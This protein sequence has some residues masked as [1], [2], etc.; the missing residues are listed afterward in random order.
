MDNE[1]GLKI[2]QVEPSK[3]W[4]VGTLTR[5][6]ILR[7]QPATQKKDRNHFKYALPFGILTFCTVLVVTIL[8]N[9]H[10]VKQGNVGPE[11]NVEEIISNTKYPFEIADTT[12]MLGGSMVSF[13]DSGLMDTTSN[14]TIPEATEA[15]EFTKFDDSPTKLSQP[16]LETSNLIENQA[17]TTVNLERRLPVVEINNIRISSISYSYGP[18]KCYGIDQG[19]SNDRSIT[20][21]RITGEKNLFAE[22]EEMAISKDTKKQVVLNDN[23]ES[24][25]NLQVINNLGSKFYSKTFDGIVDSYELENIFEVWNQAFLVNFSS[26]SKNIKFIGYDEKFDQYKFTDVVQVECAMPKDFS[27]DETDTQTRL[28]D[29]EVMYLIARDNFE[30]LSRSFYS[31]D[32]VI[33]HEDYFSEEFSYSNLKEEWE[34]INVKWWFGDLLNRIVTNLDSFIEENFEGI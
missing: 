24:N 18:A 30:I 20:K 9:P 1:L 10:V 8:L 28:K 13:N 4:Q 34:N 2:L 21:L 29:V 11:Y 23:F 19:V 7:D 15:P 14:S 32:Q 26:L 3:E 6:Q 17:E 5:L 16:E 27:I 22:V 33:L 12:Q 25:I 31:E